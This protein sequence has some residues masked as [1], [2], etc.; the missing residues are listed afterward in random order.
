MTKKVCNRMASNT[1][2]YC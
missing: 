2:L 1:A